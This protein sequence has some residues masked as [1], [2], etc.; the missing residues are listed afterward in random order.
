MNIR[1]ITE[2][3]DIVLEL[4]KQGYAA[5][6]VNAANGFVNVVEDILVIDGNIVSPEMLQAQKLTCDAVY[7]ST[8]RPVTSKSSRLRVI[9]VSA[10]PVEKIGG[11]IVS[12]LKKAIAIKA[13]HNTAIFFGTVHEAGTTMVVQ[14]IANALF[15]NTKSTILVMSL[16]E[17]QGLNY[18]DFSETRD[19][20]DLLPRVSMGILDSKELAAQ[21]V[22]VNGI[23]YIHGIQS[24]SNIPDYSIEDVGQ[25]IKIASES[26]DYVL[27]DAGAD[28][29]RMSLASLLSGYVV[30]VVTTPQP[31]AYMRFQTFI[32]EAIPKV[33]LPTN[34]MRLIV[35]K[36]GPSDIVRQI[37]NQYN[38]DIQE[39]GAIP[40]VEQ[41]LA[42]R[43]ELER[44]PL[45]LLEAPGVYKKGILSVAKE[46]MRPMGVNIEAL[47]KPQ[48]GGL[49]G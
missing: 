42:T 49:F 37:F 23:S 18:E 40:L 10:V 30:Y 7:L 33:N 28:V 2:R 32:A 11:L 41:T 34:K 22:R 45:S 20:V 21:V 29:N 31:K 26:F 9:D 13:S 14:E 1:V 6:Q 38:K 24:I 35:N 47:M 44:K 5:R 25:L 8:G 36:I 46:T 27:I 48:R 4:N 39:I 12:E 17:G 15:A 43:S 16:T 19:V 3:T